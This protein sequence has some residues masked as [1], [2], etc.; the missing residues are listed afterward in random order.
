[1]SMCLCSRHWIL[2]IICPNEGDIFILDPLD[3]DE[4]TYKKFINYIQR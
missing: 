4:S 2:I 1:M 3:I